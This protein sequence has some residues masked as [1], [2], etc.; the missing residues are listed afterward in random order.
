MSGKTLKVLYIHQHI[1]PS[2]VLGSKVWT[3]ISHFK[4]VKVHPEKMYEWK[5][6][7]LPNQTHP[8]GQQEMANVGQK[9]VVEPEQEWYFHSNTSAS[10]LNKLYRIL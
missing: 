4:Q 3:T 1:L 2:N 6:L 7:Q 10:V 9:R 5:N 8:N